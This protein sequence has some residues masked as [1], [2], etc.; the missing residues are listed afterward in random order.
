MREENGRIAWR[1]TLSLEKEGCAGGATGWLF[2]FQHH[3]PGAS[4]HPS[5]PGGV[6]SSYAG[7]L[8]TIKSGQYPHRI[9]AIDGF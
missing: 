2:K 3:H 5:W 7:S 4:R 1:V 9:S 8:R 6:I